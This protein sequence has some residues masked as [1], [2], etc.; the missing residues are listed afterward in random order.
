MQDHKFVKTDFTIKDMARQLNLTTEGVRYYEKQGIVKFNRN[1]I[2][3]HSMFR[4]RCVTVLRFVRMYNAMGI[5]LSDIGKLLNMD[6]GDLGEMGDRLKPLEEQ[7]ERKI[8]WESRMLDRIREQ[9]DYVRG[10]AEYLPAFVFGLS[11]ELYVLRY[12]S[13]RNLRE[14]T[15]L[16]RAVQIWQDL[17]PVAFPVQLCPAGGLELN[18]N[19][20]PMGLALE[21]GDYQIALGKEEGGAGGIAIE[22]MPARLCLCTSFY[23]DGDDRITL[24]HKF[25]RELSYISR[26]NMRISSDIIIRP[27]A[28]NRQREGYRIHCL[29]WLPVEEVD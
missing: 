23:E 6:D 14:D 12:G 25:E 1:E 10:I 21:G 8:W 3:G 15:L 2:N 17:T 29:A 19:D 13:G 20:L 7:Q 24:A 27:V 16:S 9:A 5:P 28:V 26:R 18:C 11:P 4:S 22:H